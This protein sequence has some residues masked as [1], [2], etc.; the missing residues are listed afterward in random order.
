MPVKNAIPDD[1]E[2]ESLDLAQQTK[3]QKVSVNVA[4][5]K[6]MQDMANMLNEQRQKLD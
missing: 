3:V 4:D 5:P 1:D 6:I 2:E